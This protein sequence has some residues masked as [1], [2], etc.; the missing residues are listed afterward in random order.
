MNVFSTSAWKLSEFK[1]D[2]PKSNSCVCLYNLNKYNYKDK[3]SLSYQNIL[4]SEIDYNK[5]IYYEG[6]VIVED[7]QALGKF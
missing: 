7:E 2:R 6:M 1:E 3:V 5:I 4:S